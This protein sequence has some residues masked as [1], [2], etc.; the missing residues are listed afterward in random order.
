MMLLMEKFE[1]ECNKK[2][3]ESSVENEGDD[4]IHI[5]NTV[6]LSNRYQIK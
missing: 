1:S 5:S 6:P 2:S 3:N 4:H